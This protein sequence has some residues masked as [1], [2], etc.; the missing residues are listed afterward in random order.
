M[1]RIGDRMTAVLSVAWNA[2]WGIAVGV[3]ALWAFFLLMGAISASDPLWLTIA[4]CVLA[5]LAT[6]HFVHVRRMLSDRDHSD[7]ARR[8]HMLRERRGF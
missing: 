6:I 1:G 7:L 3:I 2:F 8:V 4:M 5:V